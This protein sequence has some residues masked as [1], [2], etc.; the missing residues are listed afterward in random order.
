MKDIIRECIKIK[1]VH[2]SP[3]NISST[4]GNTID[5]KI[6]KD[7]EGVCCEDGYILRDSIQ[8]IER[9]MGK[10]INVNNQSKITYNIKYKCSIINPSKGMKIDCYINSV[11]KMGAVAYIKYD[12]IK[13]FK[14]SPLLII[15]PKSYSPEAESLEI[16][17][18]HKIEILATRLKY[19]SNQI[20]V[21]AKLV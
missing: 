17:T 6:K 3:S 16:N 7:M 18:K 14:D 2:V 20:H 13:D 9:S 4:I 15:I 12:E 5:F 1:E 11:T 8:I 21:V 10:I 19:R